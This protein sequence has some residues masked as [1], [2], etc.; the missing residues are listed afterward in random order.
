MLVKSVFWQICLNLILI[1]SVFLY[2]SVRKESYSKTKDI[3]DLSYNVGPCSSTDN[4][5]DF[6][7]RLQ[8]NLRMV[9]NLIVYIMCM[10]KQI[11]K[12]ERRNTKVETP[13]FWHLIFMLYKLILEVQYFEEPRT[14]EIKN[15]LSCKHVF[16]MNF[17]GIKLNWSSILSRFSPPALN[18]F[19]LYF[20]YLN[21]TFLWGY[22]YKNEI[23]LYTLSCLI[24]DC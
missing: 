14:Y 12:S 3:E 17:L 11:L 16:T 19:T 21:V 13:H 20:L 18:N 2:L 9:M 4:T 10:S 7:F 1:F 23:Q 22:T 6:G 24:K 15:V 5:F 8:N